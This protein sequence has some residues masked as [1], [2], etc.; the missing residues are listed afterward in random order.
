MLSNNLVIF[1]LFFLLPLRVD[2]NGRGVEEV[3]C[4]DTKLVV[5]RSK[6]DNISEK[7]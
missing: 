4:R 3:V 5:A 2:V 1:A 7:V 6:L